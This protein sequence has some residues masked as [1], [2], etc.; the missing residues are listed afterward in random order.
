MARIT[1]VIQDLENG[2]VNVTGRG[3]DLSK[4]DSEPTNAETL[5]ACIMEFMYT[6]DIISNIEETKY[7]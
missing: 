1:L 2:K 3:E 5:A 6:T 4:E 7:H